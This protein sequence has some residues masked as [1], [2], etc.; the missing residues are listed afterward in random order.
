MEV[1]VHGVLLAR[2]GAVVYMYI[3]KCVDILF[4][5]YYALPT[6]II[7]HYLPRLIISM[8]YLLTNQIQ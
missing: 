4:N 1:C 3:I 7:M 8:H 5:Y 6:I 2:E